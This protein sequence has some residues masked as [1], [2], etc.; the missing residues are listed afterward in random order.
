M[1]AVKVVFITLAHCPLKFA[2]LAL[3]LALLTEKGTGVGVGPGP[4]VA[5]AVGVPVVGVVPPPEPVVV[6]PPPTLGE[7]DV[8]VEPGPTAPVDPPHA[9]I[10][11]AMAKSTPNQPSPVRVA[12]A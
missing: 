8:V 12:E 5:V 3:T 11:S 9:S 4:R 7:V 1:V 10:T 6:G 2:G